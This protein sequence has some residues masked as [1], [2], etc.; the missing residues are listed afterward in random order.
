MVSV[1]VKEGLQHGYCGC[2]GGPETWQ[3]W[4]LR[5]AC[6]M[7]TVGVKEGLQHGN[8]TPTMNDDMT[9]YRRELARI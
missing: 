9:I 1:G 4:V 6:N 5:G 7:A 3:L 8:R 2:S